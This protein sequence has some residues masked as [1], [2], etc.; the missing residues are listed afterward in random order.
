[1]SNLERKQFRCSFRDNDRQS[2]TNH[3]V[4][5]PEPDVRRHNCEE[6]EDQEYCR[7]GTKDDIPEP[8]NE[9]DLLVDDVLCQDTESIVRL[10]ATSC[11]YSRKLTGHLSGEGCT[12]RV[13]GG[14]TLYYR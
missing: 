5:H 4:N 6:S 9:V 10:G 14:R 1:M 13:P 7:D 12:H 2:S 3:F 11:S 8:E